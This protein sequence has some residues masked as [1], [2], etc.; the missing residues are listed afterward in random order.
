[1]KVKLSDYLVDKGM[2]GKDYRKYE[3]QRFLR[4]VGTDKIESISFAQFRDYLIDR[5]KGISYA[6][7][8]KINSL[9]SNF[10]FW[11]AQH[12]KN[13]KLLTQIYTDKSILRASRKKKS[14][15]YNQKDY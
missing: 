3:I 9:L 14:I 1:M 4:W 2:V 6:T 15:Q 8:R 12:N 11:V 7:L 13:Y 10:L 5:S